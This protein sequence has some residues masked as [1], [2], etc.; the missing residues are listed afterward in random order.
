MTLDESLPLLIRLAGIGHLA[1]LLP[2]ALVPSQL[3]W[4]TEL[5]ALSRL[6]RQMHWVY[7]GYV[8]LSISAFALISLFY[9]DD[10][11]AGSGLARAVSAYIAVFWAVRVVLQ[12]VFDVQEHLTAW[13]LKAGYHA[14]TLLFLG[15]VIIYGAAALL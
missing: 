15:L 1:I 11:A 12:F 10:L 5:A 6:N 13:W 8:V 7:G 9:A 14:L 3:K 4:K 2:A